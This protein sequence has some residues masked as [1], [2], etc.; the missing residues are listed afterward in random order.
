[1]STTTNKPPDLMYF[2]IKAY[3]ATTTRFENLDNIQ[4]LNDFVNDFTPRGFSKF[5]VKAYDENGPRSIN[6]FSTMFNGLGDD[7]RKGLGGF[8]GFAVRISRRSLLEA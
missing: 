4:E 7:V 5:I 2:S 8:D 6:F 3:S 1:M